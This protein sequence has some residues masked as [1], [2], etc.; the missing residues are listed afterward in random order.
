MKYFFCDSVL[1]VCVGW[2][3]VLVGVADDNYFNH[4]LIVFAFIVVGGAY[5]FFTK[6]R[7]RAKKRA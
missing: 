1:W 3:G 6:V 2:C 4:S 5:R 7:E